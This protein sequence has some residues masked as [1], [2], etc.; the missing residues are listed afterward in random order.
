MRE[1]AG[2]GTPGI[3][4]IGFGKTPDA[5]GIHVGKSLWLEWIGLAF[6]IST[7]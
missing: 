7:F 5:L 6:G 2:L 1:L 3:D 4:K